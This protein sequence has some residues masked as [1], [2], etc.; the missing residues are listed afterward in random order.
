MNARELH[1]LLT[2]LGA[3][4]EVANWTKGKSLRKAW[5]SC[6]RADW[7]FLLLEKTKDEP[8][9]PS[10]QTI[11]LLACDCA[12]TIKKL[13]P[14]SDER[15]AYRNALITARRWVRG[16]AT[17]EDVEKAALE[18]HFVAARER[19][20]STSFAARSKGIFNIIS[21]KARFFRRFAK[22]SARNSFAVM[23]AAEAAYV[24]KDVTCA[25]S[26]VIAVT[27]AVSHDD[28]FARRAVLET[29]AATGEEAIHKKMCRLIRKRVPYPIV[30]K[31]E[32]TFA[33]N[34]KNA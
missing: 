28:S 15:D 7:M 8:G 20:E 23:A 18:A 24:A 31:A 14:H 13:F 2:Q 29:G 22:S 25:T 5:Q 10:Q 16:K 27:A 32:D 30:G 19:D 12:E 11:V 21:G 34:D 6:S 3:S 4:E 9:W 33:E 1:R 26:A 17:L